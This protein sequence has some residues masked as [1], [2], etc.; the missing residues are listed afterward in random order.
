MAQPAPASSPAGPARPTSGGRANPLVV[1]P[2]VT[3]LI[4][5]MI[6][7]VAGPTWVLRLFAL[8]LA[9]LL[10]YAASLFRPAVRTHLALLA[11][12]LILPILLV[13]LLA[14]PDVDEVVRGRPIANPKAHETGT[15]QPVDSA[16]TTPS[17]TA[18]AA[19]PAADLSGRRLDF[20][21]LNGAKLSYVRLIG[22]SLRGATLRGADLTG[23]DLQGADLTG[24]DLSSACLDQA[25]LISAHIENIVVAG[26]SL[27]KA[28][29]P[30]G[31]PLTDT[32]SATPG[33]ASIHPPCSP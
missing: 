27:E 3:I 6:G 15:I 2:A 10:I 16:S 26:V 23:A 5:A 21:D 30:V 14:R 1:V 22:A 18:S 9:G 12:A 8:T 29:L 19:P 33:S 7:E 31:F 13:W 25:N 28:K 24:A 11:T 4:A 20:A 32:S 17:T